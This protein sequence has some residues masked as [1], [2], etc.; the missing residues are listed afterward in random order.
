MNSQ[1]VINPVQNESNWKEIINPVGVYNCG[2][3]M[4]AESNIKTSC[5]HYFHY[6]CISQGKEIIQDNGVGEGCPQCS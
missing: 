5:G 3:C 6:G 1:E 4:K 2:V